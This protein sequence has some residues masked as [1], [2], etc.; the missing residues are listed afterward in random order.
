[1]DPCR[2]WLVYELHF[3]P[4]PP[5]PS[6][7]DCNG[8]QFD[9][10]LFAKG[11]GGYAQGINNGS[12]VFVDAPVRAKNDA[13]YD[14]IACTWST[15]AALLAFT[16]FTNNYGV[17]VCI[18]HHLRCKDHYATIVARSLR[19]NRDDR[20]IRFIRTMIHSP[21]LPA[22]MLSVLSLQLV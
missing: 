9:D 16:A 18:N 17:E 20:M 12:D 21:Q 13:L 5:L 19:W 10:A 8:D 6:L 1:M 2:G 4:S 3:S 11:G 14:A 7:S 15:M 22:A